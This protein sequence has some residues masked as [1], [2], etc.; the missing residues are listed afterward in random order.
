[1]TRTRSL[2]VAAAAGLLVLSACES[3]Q[4]PLDAP[5]P[6]GPAAAQC[7]ALIDDLPDTVNDQLRRPV[8]PSDALGAAWGDPAIVVLC[9]GAMPASYDEFSACDVADGVGW[10]V[11]PEQI[12]D[13]SLDAVITT[14]GLRPIVQLR[15]PADY[16][17]EGV[18]AAMVELAPAIKKHLELVRPCT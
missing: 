8:S 1:M 14:I 13:Q 10:Y 11:P 17:P 16:R 2:R 9:G 3:D 15:I 6:T 12:E 7:A 4:V 18:A 5:Q